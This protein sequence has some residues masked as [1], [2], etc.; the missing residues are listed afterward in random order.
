[1]I[2]GIKI[3][4]YP[5]TE[6]EILFW[7]SCGLARFAYNWGLDYQRKNREQGGKYIPK[8]E[9]RKLFKKFRDENE[10]MKWISECSSE[11]P[12]QALYDLDEAYNRF[13]S[14]A[15]KFPKFKK[16]FK[17]EFSFYHSSNKI[18]VKDN[19]IRLEKIGWV[20]MNDENRLVRGKYKGK[21]KAQNA[22]VYNPRI[23]YNG[24]YWY[25]SVGIDVADISNERKTDIRLGID[26]GLKEFATCS[27]GTVFYNINKS[28][29][30][31]RL[32]KKLKREQR[33]LSR[34]QRANIDYYEK[35]QGKDHKEHLKPVWKR[36]LK[37]CKN[38]Q[39]QNK[40]I[41]RI[42][43]RI[44]NIRLNH[45]HQVSNSI[46]KTKP[47]AI[48]VE[49]L[50]IQ[51]MMKNRH[52]SKAIQDVSWYRFMTF[53]K[54]KSERNGIDFIKADRF[55][56]SSK[57]CSKCGYIKKDLQLKDRVFKCPCCNNTIDRDFNAS[58]NLANY[59]EK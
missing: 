31:K 47:K 21:D 1:M 46:V 3:R 19:L 52:L 20:K 38:I 23:K 13:F 12:D 29:E 26:V 11:I 15:S 27:D 53:L 59:I 44:N 22:K 4:L 48:V 37:D 43:R 7:K 16:K 8:G 57:K 41:K 33:K 30:I 25:L 9:M 39:K 17:S 18:I 50:N 49:D 36:P 51:G 45:Q 54:Y 32:T 28:K 56:P 35:I 10:D 55:Y 24:K 42:H 40:K 58:I 2:R 34:Q 14:G 5:T 6:Q